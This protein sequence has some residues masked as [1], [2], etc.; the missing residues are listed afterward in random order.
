MSTLSRK[1]TQCQSVL[2]CADCVRL[3]QTASDCVNFSC[4]L[5][6][7]EKELRA[8]GLS[9]TIVRP[10]G[11]SN[12]TPETVGKLCACLSPRPYK[13]LFAALRLFTLWL[14]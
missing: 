9:W 5:W 14:S 2:V 13:F 7:A 10:G 4:V 1:A 8:S 12:D 3:C 6:Q 11:L